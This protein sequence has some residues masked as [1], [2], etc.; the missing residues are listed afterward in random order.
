ME[1]EVGS[2]AREIVKNKDKKLTIDF[3]PILASQR[4]PQVYF[5]PRCVEISS[6][7]PC[8]LNRND[9]LSPT[10]VLMLL[11]DGKLGVLRLPIVLDLASRKKRVRDWTER[12]K[13]SWREVWYNI[14]R[15]QK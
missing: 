13:L 12:K 3:F 10:M 5:A 2:S 6:V 15:E 14:W 1:Y 11:K 7:P 9:V 8:C 4:C